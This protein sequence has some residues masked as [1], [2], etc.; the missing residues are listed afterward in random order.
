[1]STTETTEPVSLEAFDEINR[2]LAKQAIIDIVSISGGKLAMKTALFKAFYFAHLFY[3]RDNHVSLTEY[4]V[5]CM[6]KGPGIDAANSLI[7]ELQAEGKMKVAHYNEGPY[8][9]YTYET[10]G[11][12]TIEPESPRYK[13]ISEALEYIGVRMQVRCLNSAMITV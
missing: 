10:V 11:G 7:A 12:Y 13:A 4:P 8:E 9:E 5:V 2:N 1:M 6:P 3:Y